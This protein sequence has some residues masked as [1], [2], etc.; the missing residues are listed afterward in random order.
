LAPV[1]AV[2]KLALDKPAYS[3]ATGSKI[4]PIATVTDSSGAPLAGITVT[5]VVDKPTA[6]DMTAVTDS[7]GKASVCFTSK[8]AGTGNLTASAGVAAA[9]LTATATVAFGTAT[10]PPTVPVVAPAFTG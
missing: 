9:Q 1:A 4:C 7:S 2:S 10:P 5:F 6:I 8:V 3:A